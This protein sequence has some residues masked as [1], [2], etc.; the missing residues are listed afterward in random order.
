MAAVSVDTLGTALQGIFWGRSSLTS[1]CQWTG[2][3][4]MLAFHKLCS[5][6]H[7]STSVALN[8]YPTV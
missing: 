2:P 3:V 5:D 6:Y 8:F 1:A 7:S 4:G